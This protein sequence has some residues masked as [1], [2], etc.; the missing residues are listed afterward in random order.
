MKWAGGGDAEATWEPAETIRSCCG[1][2]VEAYEQAKRAA[3]EH[4]AEEKVKAEAAAAENVGKEGC[5]KCGESMAEGDEM[6]I[7]D[8]AHAGL[9]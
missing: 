6:S 2:L 1:P 5:A 9:R 3:E 4:E 7:R 8:G